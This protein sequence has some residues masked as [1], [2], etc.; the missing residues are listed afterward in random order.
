[1]GKG[2]SQ[3]AIIREFSSGGVVFK[4]QGRVVLWLITKSQPSDR[5]P[6]P[7]WRLPK[8][9]IDNKSKSL[10]GAVA[11]G[12]RRGS[13][14]EIQQAALREV[15]EEGGVEAKIMKKLGTIQFFFSLQGQRILKFVT[16]YLMEWIKD[17]KQGFGEETQEVEWLPFAE[18]YKK[19]KYSSEKATLKKANDVIQQGLQENLI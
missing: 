14:D 3:K 9:W 8:G 11:S 15:R 12:I 19:L 10:P 16:F 4:K 13:E 18:A 17:L 2:T 7:V 6:N 5:V 1:M